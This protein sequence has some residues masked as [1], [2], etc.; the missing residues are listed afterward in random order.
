MNYELLHNTES[1]FPLSIEMERE[2]RLIWPPPK[3]NQNSSEKIHH[4]I[5]YKAAENNSH[6]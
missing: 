6:N 3:Q 4:F 5:N 1:L 2:D